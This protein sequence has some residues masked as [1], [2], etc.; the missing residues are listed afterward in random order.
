[1]PELGEKP[2]EEKQP[3]PNQQPSQEEKSKVFKLDEKAN[4]RDGFCGV[5]RRGTR[6]GCQFCCVRQF[7]SPA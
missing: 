6:F 3:E 5:L 2:E 1:M 7:S 4:V